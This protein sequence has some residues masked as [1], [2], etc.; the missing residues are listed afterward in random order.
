M[1]GVFNLRPSGCPVQLKFYQKTGRFPSTINEIPET[2]L[3]YLANQ[4]DV[5]V[6]G[7][8]DYE[9][10]GRTGARHRKE[11]LNFL[12]IRR[13][14]ATDKNAFSDWLINTLYQNHFPVS[15]YWL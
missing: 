10:S 5:D 1:A 12:G 11:I 6:P 8:Q 14:S 3:H 9:W 13:V 7:L 15:V 2:P 4:L